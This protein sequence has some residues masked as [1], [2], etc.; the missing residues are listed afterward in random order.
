M[1][2]TL[3]AKSPANSK[4]HNDTSVHC[5][6]SIPDYDFLILT[7]VLLDIVLPSP[8]ASLNELIYNPLVDDLSS[9]IIFEILRLVD[10]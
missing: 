6:V 10:Q 8:F 7:D 3:S 2:A 5:N 9:R 4:F 1:A